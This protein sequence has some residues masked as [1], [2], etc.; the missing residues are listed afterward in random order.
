MPFWKVGYFKLH[1]KREEETK[2]EKECKRNHDV[3]TAWWLMHLS[4]RQVLCMVNIIP[5]SIIPLKEIQWEY[6]RPTSTVMS[7][8]RKQKKSRTC[9]LG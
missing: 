4:V 3:S 7:L 8:E 5:L 9:G 6:K 2:R 1:W